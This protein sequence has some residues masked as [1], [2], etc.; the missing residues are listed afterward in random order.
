MKPGIVIAGCA[1]LVLFGLVGCEKDTSVSTPPSQNQIDDAVEKRLA[2]VD[3]L[4]L[5]QSQKDAMKERIK[6]GSAK[7]GPGNP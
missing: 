1:A 3:K 5:P 7:R 4:N 2:E 6:P